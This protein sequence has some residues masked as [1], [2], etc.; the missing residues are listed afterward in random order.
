MLMIQY[1]TVQ[2]PLN[3]KTLINLTREVLLEPY[4]VC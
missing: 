3:K 4:R 1:Q 2:H